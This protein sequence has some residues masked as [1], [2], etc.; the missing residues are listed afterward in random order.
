M[1]CIQDTFRSQFDEKDFEINVRCPYDL[2]SVMHYPLIAF[3]KAGKA[4]M[5]VLPNVTVPEDKNI[6]LVKAVSPQ[7]GLLHLYTWGLGSVTCIFVSSYPPSPTYT[8]SCAD[9]NRNGEIC[10]RVKKFRREIW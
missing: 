7:E 8:H 1:E 9:E 4:S 2:E 5:E 6:G 10:G 3:A